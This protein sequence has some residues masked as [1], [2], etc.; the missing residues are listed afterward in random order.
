MSGY[1]PPRW[2]EKTLEWAVPR[3]LSGQGTLGDLAEEFER[4][5]L[6]SPLRARLWY[7][8]QTVS[9]VGY[10]IFTGSGSEGSSSDS[11]LL[12]DLRW[13]LRKILKHPGFSFGVVR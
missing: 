5:A 2:L 10:R 3:G 6:E 7:A 13:S 12:M 1:R 11:D 9:I 4:Q 8:R